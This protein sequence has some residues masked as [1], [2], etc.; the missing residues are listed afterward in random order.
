MICDFGEALDVIF[1]LRALIWREISI[2]WLKFDQPVSI[3]LNSSISTKHKKAASLENGLVQNL[4]IV[5][6]VATVVGP[7]LLFSQN[8]WVNDVLV[9]DN[10][11]DEIITMLYQEI[12]QISEAAILH[13]Y[14]HFACAR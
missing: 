6:C 8:R 7:A 3:D 4:P 14:H 1:K 2:Q 12:L 13:D 11:I 5:V 10:L 9:A